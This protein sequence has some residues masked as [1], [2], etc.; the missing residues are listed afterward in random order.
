MGDALYE[1]EQILRSKQDKMTSQEAN[2]IMACKA[3]A[4]R[5]FTIGVGVGAGIT[6]F[7]SRR[8]NNF[9]RINLSGGKRCHQPIPPPFLLCLYIYSSFL[10]VCP[11]YVQFLNCFVKKPNDTCYW[12]YI[13]QFFYLFFILCYILQKESGQIVH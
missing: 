8:L 12:L 7:A 6:W 1:L 11:F 13:V 2:V 9:F 4:M 3:N 5:E 10:L